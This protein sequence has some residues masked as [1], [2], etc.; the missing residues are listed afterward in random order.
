MLHTRALKLALFLFLLSGAA[1]HAQTEIPEIARRIPPTSKFKMPAEKKQELQDRLEQLDKQ[2]NS[3]SD[4]AL[5]EDATVFLKAVDWALK[6][7]E[8]YKPQDLAKA[9]QLLDVAEQRIALLK[10]NKTPWT[11]ASGFV[12]R[13]YRS[14]VDTSI[15]PYGLVIPEKLDLSKPQPLYVWLHGRGDTKT[16]MHFIYERLTQKGQIAPEDAIVIHPF[17]RQCIGF[18]SAGEIDVLDAIA[19]AQSQYNIDPRRI[20]LMGFS[21]GGAG[22]WHI[23]AHYTDQFVAMSPGAGFA[24]T[25]KYQRL[26]PENYPALYEQQ[27]WQVYDVPSYVR[28]LFNL[29]VVAYSGEKD[30]QIQ[31]ARVME[32]AFKKYESELMHLIGPGMGHKYHPETL[33]TI[34]IRMKAART[35][36]Q[37][38]YPNTVHLHTPTLRYN[39]MHWVEAFA[40]D[41]HWKES[42]ID[43]HWND[44][45]HL[46]IVTDNIRK[47]RISLEMPK[48]FEVT[49][50]GTTLQADLAGN[51]VYFEKSD[52]AWKLSA[53][54]S[55]E[56][57]SKKPGLQGPIDDAFLDPFLV[58]LP[59]T[60]SKNQKLQ[61]WID[62]EIE[63][64][65]QRWDALF[66]G[67]LRIKQDVDVTPEDIKN[68]HLVCWGTPETNVILQRSMDGLPLDWN[69][70][71][72]AIGDRAFDAE[73]HVPLMIYPNPLNSDRYLVVNSGPTF[74]ELHD[75]TNSLQ[76]PKLPDWAIIDLRQLPDGQSP[77]KVAAAQFFD[78]QWNVK[79]TAK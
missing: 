65:I 29:P 68:Y 45:E 53:K 64:L 63:H 34:M 8:F 76:N 26:Q 31:A 62:F 79:P 10:K 48:K 7:N 75:R 66:R 28:N 54:P 69:S 56:P 51:E 71:Q 6:W 70:A 52:G 55:S 16:D 25:A 23:G 24:E 1:L 11:S 3:L 2:A 60:K 49:I 39:Q 22:V 27:L 43:A 19:H 33:A 20:V 32:Q 9:D 17:G 73:N 57:L 21:M 61:T 4:H 46:T 37:N 14:D 36:G 58:V 41:E 13:G 12:V 35:A 38:P 77:G 67:Q 5:I 42:R 30:K 74:R 50:N 78:E 72:V 40:L 44:P 59:S 18:K 15:Q 47:L